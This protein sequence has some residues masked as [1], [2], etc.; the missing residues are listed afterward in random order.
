MLG[1]LG[2]GASLGALAQGCSGGGESSTSDAGAASEGGEGE[3][4]DA[5]GRGADGSVGQNTDGAVQCAPTT[6]DVQGPYYIAGAPERMK[7]AADN[8][9][10]ERLVISGRVFG[11]DCE[12]PLA[13]AVVDVWQA[14]AQG[15]Y[16]G[17]EQ[18]YR[19]RGVMRTDSDGNYAFETIMPGRYAIETGFRP[20][21]IHFMVSYPG[22]KPLITQLYFAGDPYL[23]PNDACGPGC[24]SD[25]PDRIITLDEANGF[26]GV[27]DI[28]LAKA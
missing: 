1:V 22:Y 10:G 3:Q 7:I 24:N 2:A 19:L 12:T 6:S 8:E 4:G 16:H 5:S 15:N 28:I 11:P 27:F 9:P 13:D 20:A 26:S 17:A 21:H 18:N 25:E 23:P 14:D